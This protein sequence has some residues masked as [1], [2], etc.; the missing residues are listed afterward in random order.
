[1]IYRDRSKMEFV[2]LVKFDQA[3]VV[4]KEDVWIK[5]TLVFV[6]RGLCKRGVCGQ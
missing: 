1:M 6:I 4:F 5:R 3:I 2:V